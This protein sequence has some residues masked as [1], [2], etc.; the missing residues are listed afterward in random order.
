MGLPALERRKQKSYKNFNVAIYC[1][2][3]NINNIDDF[4]EFDRKFE[5]AFGNIKVGRVYLEDFRGGN[6][7]SKDRLLKLKEY[8]EKKGIATAGGI[9]TCAPKSPDFGFASLCY[10]SEEGQSMIK[11]AV[12][13]NAELFDEVIFD[14]FYFINCRCP[15]CIEKKESYGEKLNWSQFRLKQKRFVTEELVMKTAKEINP[16]INVIVKFP[17]WYED[18]NETGY[19]L[20]I[21][22]SLFDNI[23]TGTETRNPT[24]SQQHLPKYLSYNTMR[25]YGSNKPGRN[26]GGWFDPYECT[27]NLTSY[28]EQGY[29]TMFAKAEEVTLFCLGSLM[30]D[31]QFKLFP[32][33]CAQMFA[34]ADSYLG[35]LGNPV[36][37][38]AYHPSYGTGEKNIHS[39]LGQCGI[40]MEMCLDYP[41]NSK[42]VFLAESA[43]ADKDIVNKMKKSLM[44]GSDVIVTSGFVQAMGKDFEEFANIQYTTRKAIV[45]DYCYSKNCGINLSGKYAGEKPV[46]IPQLDFCTN[47]TW[48]IAAA[49]GTDNNFPIILSF[50]YGNGTVSVITIPDDMGDLYNYP[51]EILTSIRNLFVKE[52]GSAIDAPSNVQLFLYDNDYF[53]LR[54][55][56]PY[57][58]EVKVKLPNADAKIEI[59]NY[60]SAVI[61]DMERVSEGEAARING[62]TVTLTIGSGIN[63]VCKISK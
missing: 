40:P 23:Y 28:V 37:A 36:G 61:A 63:Y 6:T 39:Y 41:E 44:N 13:L 45:K 55:D 56:L 7:I 11:E 34:E 3:E 10:S 24:Y 58:T 12:K 17:Q 18:F 60:N 20:D 30:N 57:E 35:L 46:L 51:R 8:F 15:K 19:D 29:L 21:D 22:T 42:S 26:L 47:D 49:F 9:T 38:G 33:A 62:S 4:E 16:D 50:S 31:P 59:L 53:I 43:A 14:D 48:E 5:S 54:S 32:D 25:L 52:C 2:V 27:Y 1:P